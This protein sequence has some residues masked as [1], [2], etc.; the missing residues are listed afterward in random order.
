MGTDINVG[1]DMIGVD[2]LTHNTMDPESKKKSRSWVGGWLQIRFYNP[3]WLSSEL[4][5]DSESKFEPS[6]AKI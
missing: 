6:V 5:L 4:S 3:L 2:R 1:T